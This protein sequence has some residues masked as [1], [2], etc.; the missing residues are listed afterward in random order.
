M[1]KRAP[2]IVENEVDLQS[3]CKSRLA[4]KVRISNELAKFLDHR[5][6]S[7]SLNKYYLVLITS[8]AP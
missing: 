1:V 5:T 3:I 4:F 7:L 6:N 8:K 2:G